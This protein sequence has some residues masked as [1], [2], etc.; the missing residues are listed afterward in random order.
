MNPDLE[1]DNL[2]SGN[3]CSANPKMKQKLSQ[4]AQRNEVTTFPVLVLEPI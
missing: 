2:F 1:R 3:E 4:T